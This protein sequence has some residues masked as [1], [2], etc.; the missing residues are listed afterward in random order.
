MSPQPLPDRIGRYE[1]V[2]EIG[3]GAMGRV[4]RARDPNVDRAVALKVLGA[5]HLLGG[6]AAEE[7]ARRR[8]L[9][10]ARAAGRLSHPG[11][12]MVLDADSDP[13]TGA[14]YIAME[15]VEGSSLESLLGDYR[16]LS[17]ARA[18]AIVAAAARALAYAHSQGIVHRDVKPTNI[19][20]ADSGAVKLAD[21]GIAKM[22]A[23]RALTLPGSVLGSPFYMSPE[24]ARGESLD[25]RS[26]LFSLGSVL[27]RAVTGS[28][29]FGG[30]DIPAVL[31]KVAH[32]DPR[33]ARSRVLG[34]PL[35]LERL[36][37]RALAKDRAAR[38]QDGEEMAAALDAVAAEL[39]GGPAR[40]PAASSAAGPWTAP[41]P[42]AGAPPAA[43]PRSAASDTG[44][45]GVA[46]TTPGGTSTVVLEAPPP[47][48]ASAASAVARPGSGIPAAGSGGPA[49]AAATSAPAGRVGAT[50]WPGARRQ[51]P[52]RIA[53][54]ATA[55]SL[56]AL[57]AVVVS[58]LNE[59]AVE[60]ASGRPAASGAPPGGDAAPALPQ[61]VRGVAQPSAVGEGS[62]E[63]SGTATAPASLHLVYN[64]RL[65]SATVTVWIDGRW[66]WSESIGGTRGIAQRVVGRERRWVV[67]VPPGERSVRVRIVGSGPGVEVD[68]TQLVRGRLAAGGRHFLRVALN[69][70]SNHL[71][72]T[73]MDWMG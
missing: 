32:L 70:L 21:F 12:V 3:R 33:P 66:T 71:R 44:G 30:D 18:V 56:L 73:W 13:A 22:P 34:L 20:V 9:L 65:S 8:F 64:D 67:E 29:P 43:T 23:D 25:R 1:I 41:S 62:G 38:F 17:P 35:S 55:L 61:V 51:G 39:R 19:L 47:R 28:V 42:A 58:S 50:P 40:A 36:L 7:E 45:G 2:A 16:R 48:P 53:W 5:P 27:Y 60:R 26:D 49:G 52:R 68:A 31:Y 69:P 15:L 63:G 11:I 72:L 14:P 37:E 10:E 4:F 6:D 54:A 24:Q 57:G 59:G 46:G